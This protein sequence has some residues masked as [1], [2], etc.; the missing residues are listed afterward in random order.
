MEALEAAGL[1][2]PLKEQGSKTWTT[3][4]AA[5]TFASATAAKPITREKAERAL[6][7][8]LARVDR[9]NSDDGFLAKVTRVIV[10]GSY[11]RTGI[12]RLS[13]VDIAVELA[14][15]EARWKV[16]RELNYR[17]VAQSERKGHRFRGVWNGRCGG[18]L[19]L[20]VS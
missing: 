17:R 10:F 16:L 12:D 1:S 4:Q 20:S 5:Q 14:P 13:D 2:K 6:A 7:D 18:D 15:K 9:V 8:F 11:L 3:T 19:R